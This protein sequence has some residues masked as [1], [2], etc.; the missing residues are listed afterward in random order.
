MQLSNIR[1]QPHISFI[2]A[3]L[4]NPHNRTMNCRHV[5]KA[6]SR[7]LDGELPA[8]QVAHLAQHLASCASCRETA[9]DWQGYGKNLRADQPSG[10]PDPTKAWQD[11]RRAIRTKEDPVAEPNCRPWWARPL[12]WPG[13]AATVAL[14]TIV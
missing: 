1:R 2:A 6:I 3:Q 11:I 7:H 13:A 12:P 9:E 5:E 10:M 14:V 4:L 8:E